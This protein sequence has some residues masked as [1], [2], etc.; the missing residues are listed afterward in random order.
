M[1]IIE[2]NRAGSPDAGVPLVGWAGAAEKTAGVGE[3]IGVVWVVDGGSVNTFRSLS[4][5]HPWALAKATIIPQT[6]TRSG[7][8]WASPLNRSR[9]TLFSF[10]KSGVV[11]S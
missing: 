1:A 11:G 7:S 9:T 2:R 4:N 5:V 3:G 6:W 8:A 10:S